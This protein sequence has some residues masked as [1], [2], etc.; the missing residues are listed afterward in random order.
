M[1]SKSSHNPFANPA[2]AP[3]SALGAAGVDPSLLQKQQMFNRSKTLERV[4]HAAG[5]GAFGYFECTKDMSELTKADLY[6]EVGKKTP[7]FMRFSTATLGKE[8]P[9]QGRNPRGFAIKHYTKEGNYD[10]VGLNWPVFFCRDPMQGL[11]AIR[12]QQRNPANFLLDFNA[13]FDFLANVPE[14]NHAAMM[15]FSNHGH[16]KG[17]RKMHGFGCHTFKWVNKEGQYVY[18]KYH[19][20]CDQGVHQF[21]RE[22]AVQACGEDPDFSKRDLWQAIEKGE[23]VTWTAK[24]QIMK[25]EQAVPVE[26]GFDPF[27]V[28]KVWPKQDFPVQDFGRL[29]L[30]KN[31]EDYHRD[32]EQSA[33]SPGSMVPGIEES[34]DELLKFRM[35]L[36]RDAQYHRIGDNLDQAPVNCP[37]TSHSPAGVDLGGSLRGGGGAG[38]TP[39]Y[40]P[41]SLANRFR[42]GTPEVPYEVSDNV[43]SRQSRYYSQGKPQE[44]N[45]TRELYSHVMSEKERVDL[46]QNT[47][48]ALGLVEYPLIQMKYLAQCYCVKPDYARGIYDLLPRREFGFETVQEMAKDAPNFGKS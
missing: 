14:S 5:S 15:L 29:V 20:I 46:H 45:Q 44:Y 28:T 37:L 32:V 25:P 4:A 22:E 34:Q 36:Y 43:V 7:I 2:Q 48:A 11:D 19:F 47:A 23:P 39:Q 6:N 13:T 3:A 12:S 8:Y 41:D 35:S 30:N 42:P 24:V 33:F 10:I 1:T 40:F 21:T 38:G 17:W 18:I 26:L 27:D 16:P 31:P 9:D